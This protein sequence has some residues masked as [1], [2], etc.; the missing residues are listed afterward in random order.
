MQRD[1]LKTFHVDGDLLT[2]QYHYDERADV[3][4][5]QFP[6]FEEEPRYTPNGRPWKSVVSVGCP[7]ATGEFDDC[8]SCSYL[9]REGSRDI[10]GV[11]FHEQMCSR[12]SPEEDPVRDITSSTGY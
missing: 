11:C 6:E 5:G 12:A 10:A 8:G 4:I 1:K 3:F 7:Y 9:I 2:V